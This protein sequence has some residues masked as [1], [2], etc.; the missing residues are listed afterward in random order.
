MFLG[1]HAVAFGSKKIAPQ[2]KLGTL[3]FA[4]QFLDL[5]W[6]LLIIAGV[7][8]VRINSNAI[9]FLRLDLYDYPISHSMVTSLFWSLLIGGAYFLM[10]KNK[11]NAIIVGCV[12]FSHWILDLITH[13][14]DLPIIPGGAMVVGLG[15]WNSTI[16]T[17]T[18][19]LILFIVGIVYYLHFTQPINKTGKIAPWTMIVF[20]V[21]SYVAS[22]A[23]PPPPDAG[24]VGWMALSQ[25]LF[26]PWAFWIDRNRKY[27]E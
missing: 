8:H 3:V 17:I 16:G 14:P 22:F 12:V 26:I 5:L 7:E 25:W 23:G 4:A 18:L 19:E 24:P 13:I 10:N 11:H 9:P 1:H 2:I 21:S 27:S 6:P 15:L 20:L